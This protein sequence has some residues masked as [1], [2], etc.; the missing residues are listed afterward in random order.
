M[1][2]S[3]PAPPIAVGASVYKRL[4]RGTIWSIA[5]TVFSQ[6]AVLVGYILVA[7]LLGKEEFGAFGI[8]QNTAGTLGI[9]AGIGSGM[10]CTKYVA[11]FRSTDP[12]RCGRIIGLG[13][14]VSAVLAAALGAALYAFSPWLA[15]RTLAA[16][17]LAPELRTAA[18]FLFATAL[19]GAQNGVLAGLEAF[20][21]SARLSAIRG[22]ITIVLM[23]AAAQAWGLHGTVWSLAMA[24][25]I[26]CGIGQ[27][28][29]QKACAATGIRV[30]L[31]NV[32]GDMALV[33]SFSIPASLA[34]AMTGP[35]MWLAYAVLVNQPGG[36][37]QMGIFAAANHWRNALLFLPNVI[38]QPL[39]PVLSDLHGRS[40][41]EFRRV[42]WA[43]MATIGAATT[44]LAIPIVL[45]ASW[46]MGLYGPG[47][48]SFGPTL[49][50]LAASA[51]PAACSSVVG[52]GI[53]GAGRIWSGFALNLIWA[54]ML[55]GMTVLLASGY[56]ATGLSTAFLCAYVMHWITVSIFAVS[57]L[58]SSRDE[59]CQA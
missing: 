15:S 8:I 18:L 31:G 36:Y 3:I 2:A 51:V 4:C 43:T 21:R 46:I 26:G 59:F 17:G 44:L 50:L 42:L 12:Q 52:Q 40:P 47:F 57:H 22:G 1:A 41:S 20:Q 32:H 10:T 35:A 14:L 34:G 45:G 24:A 25:C 19:T 5:G 39:L 16:P 33:W 56:G 13:L 23:A 49:S 27:Y 37:G 6:G 29:L 53:A 38:G 11:Q 58:R 54:G 30:C 28:E 7:R 48:R 55:L 9:L